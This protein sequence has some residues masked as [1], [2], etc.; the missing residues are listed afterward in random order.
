MTKSWV[1][2]MISLKPGQRVNLFVIGLA[3]HWFIA[4]GSRDQ[5]KELWGIDPDDL[6][7]KM[8]AF[9]PDV[10]EVR[11]DMADYFGEIQAFDAAL[12]LMLR[13]LEAMGELDNTLVIVSGDHGAPGFPNGKCSLY[14]FGVGVP[15]PLVGVAV[16]TGAQWKILLI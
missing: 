9:L 16:R 8:P 13:K 5:G 11:Q 12:G 1:I 2:L 3:P 7:G 4:N 6:K 15:W 14:D 10:H